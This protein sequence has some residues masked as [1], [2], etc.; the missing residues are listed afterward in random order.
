MTG[1][2]SWQGRL[3][4][5]FTLLLVD[6]DG[7]E[8]YLGSDHSISTWA[9]WITQLVVEQISFLSIPLLFPVSMK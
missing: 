3:F 2:G 4:L 5:S 7:K 6:C 1:T 9:Y 8:D